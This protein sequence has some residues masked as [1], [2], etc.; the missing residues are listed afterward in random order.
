MDDKVKAVIDAY[1][2]QIRQ[3]HDALAAGRYRPSDRDQSFLAVGPETGA[4]IN[5]LARS[6][7]APT[8]LE[9]GTSFGY[10]ALW[11]ADA[12]RATDG[13][14]ITMELAEHKSAYARDK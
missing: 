1:H 14:V 12:A 6:L 9:I 5:I 7:K 13:R 10:S 3:E 2:E 4:L 8:I 11:L